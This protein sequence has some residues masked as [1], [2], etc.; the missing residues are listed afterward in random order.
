MCERARLAGTLPWR[1]LLDIFSGEWAGIRLALTGDE[2]T[3]P[4]L[5][6]GIRPCS[7]EEGWKVP[8]DWWDVAEEDPEVLRRS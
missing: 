7:A 2:A 4:S 8:L 1:W 3:E 6:F 5:R